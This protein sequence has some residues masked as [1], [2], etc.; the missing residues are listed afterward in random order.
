MKL[1]TKPF[2]AMCAGIFA[3]KFCIL[4]TL[5]LIMIS[6]FLLSISAIAIPMFFNNTS[7]ISIVMLFGIVIIR[8]RNL[9]VSVEMCDFP[10]EILGLAI[11]VAAMLSFSPDILLPILNGYL[12][13][14]YPGVRV[15]AIFCVY[16]YSLFN[17]CLLMHCFL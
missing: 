14:T 8:Q 15:S 1:W 17:W 3:D 6:L 11:G 7:I 9:F 13:E 10:K 12:L 5:L 2:G 4:K 16:G